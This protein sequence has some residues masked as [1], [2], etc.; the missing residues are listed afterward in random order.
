MT[1][2]I[3]GLIILMVL[4]YLGWSIVW[5]GP[6]AAGVVALGGG[7]DL[8]DSYTNVYMGGFVAFAKTW[9]PVFMLGAIFG[10]LMELTYM[11]S[12][13][14]L[15]IGKILGEKR[16]I[17]GV[18][19][20]AAILTYGGVS[21]FVVVFAV[22]PLALSLFKKANISK[23]LIPAAIA[24]GAFTFTMAALPGSP[25]IQN[26][27]PIKYFDTTAMA[28]PIMGIICGLIMFVGGYFYLKYRENYLKNLGEFYEES[29][30]KYQLPSDEKIPHFILSLI[31][32]LCVIILLNVFSFEIINALL[33]GIFA[34]LLLNIHRFRNFV[35]A[36]NEGVQGSIIAIIN[37]SAAVG[38]GSVVK[39]VPG[40]Q[41]LTNLL[42][43]FKINPLISEGIAVNLLAGATGSASGGMGIAL[44]ALGAK[45]KE[46]A[47]SENI[48]LELFHRVASIAS[49]GFDA[50]PHNGA[51]LTLLAITS[52]SHKKSYLD[53]C[54]VA[55][56][57]PI[58][59][60]IVGIIL[61][62]FGIY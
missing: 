25:Q 37:T 61:A 19:L 26:L 23:R 15:T 2:I 45:Y 9:F 60:L 56:I 46:I 31:P 39:A 27:I 21:L 38:F 3:L 29:K 44:E 10:K 41:T 62:Y 58:I 32:L 54:V 53:I 8:F 6:I 52:M 57:I 49:G 43:D 1:G 28:A 55:V 14:S 7:L 51:V 13:V 24:L 18:I 35:K 30:D 40:F 47:L 5:V 50:L 16:A 48:P 4:A 42:L 17:L 36:M 11:A 12:S 22:Y 33:C 20:A 34:I 59:A